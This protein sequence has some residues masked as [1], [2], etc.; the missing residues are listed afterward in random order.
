M[1]SAYVYPGGEDFGRSCGRVA[2]DAGFT[3]VD[4][5][6]GATVAVAPLLRRMLRTDDLRAPR[7]GTLVFHPS[8]LPLHRGPDAIRW[9]LHAGER[10]SA[11][12]WFWADEGCDT[13][14]VCEQDVVVLNLA[15]SPGRN[16]HTR[17]V[18]AGLRALERALRGVR[19]G[20]PRAVPQ[21]ETLATYESFFPGAR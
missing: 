9:T 2:R 7:V 8:A 16:Y 18:P 13:G 14:P 5:P 11:A 4:S 20:C 1:P 15:E 10:V 17:F 3:L 12:T 21:D 6:A 19:E